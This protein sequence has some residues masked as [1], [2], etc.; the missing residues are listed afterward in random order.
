M[1]LHLPGCGADKL[2][3]VEEPRDESDGEAKGVEERRVA[4]DGVLLT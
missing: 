3:A 4:A 2:C 1:V